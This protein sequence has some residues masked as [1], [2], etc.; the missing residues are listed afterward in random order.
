MN[1]PWCELGLPGPAGL[2]EIRHAYAQRLKQT[3]PEDDPEGFQRLHEAYVL[4]CRLARGTSKEGAKSG[5]EHVAEEQPAEEEPTWDF[6]EL[7][8]NE[9]SADAGR[10]RGKEPD[11]DFD[12]LLRGNDWGEFADLAVDIEERREMQRLDKMLDE[13]RKAHPHRCGIMEW[14]IWGRAG[15]RKAERAAAL[16]LL[17]QFEHYLET[18]A[19]ASTWR[20]FL[21]SDEFRRARYTPDLVLGLEEIL[22]SAP[23]T[24]AI[25]G[26]EIAM[27]FGFRAEEPGA[28]EYWPLYRL[29]FGERANRVIHKNVVGWLLVSAFSLALVIGLFISEMRPG[30]STSAMQPIES[31]ES[32]EAW[33]DSVCDYLS[34]DFGE[35]F[36]YYAVGGATLFTP[37]NRTGVTFSAKLTGERDLENGKRGYWT[38]YTDMRLLQELIDFANEWGYELDIDSFHDSTDEE[39]EVCY[40]IL[41][42]T[43]AGDGILELESRLR[44]LRSKDWYLTLPPAAEVRLGIGMWY[45]HSWKAERGKFDLY[46]TYMHYEAG[47][48][49]AEICAVIAEDLEEGFERI[50]PAKMISIDGESFFLAD[51]YGEGV[52]DRPKARFLLAEDAQ[53]FYCLPG[54]TNVSELTK[55]D[56]DRNTAE[57]RTISDS[58]YEVFVRDYIE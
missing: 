1:W 50:E 17:S 7:I 13:L 9:Q 27:A 46:D 36:R 22:A 31:T 32:T 37:E 11:W 30:Q 4:A 21:R 19:D 25:P 38:N 15:G 53:S 45:F 34:E 8:S 2:P 18:G 10:P 41:P 14:K 12:E 57:T 40:V 23:S 55:A 52:A 16:K 49:G 47:T 29:V 6:D 48:I 35:P 20:I 5:Q 26:E 51:G 3:H 28:P 56:L 42:M 33:Q 24:Y 43:G 39:P 54:D 44:Q 58:A